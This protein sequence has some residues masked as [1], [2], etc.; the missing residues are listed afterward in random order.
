MEHISIDRLLNGEK[1]KCPKCQMG[2]IITDCKDVSKAHWFY[3]DNK[4]CD[5]KIHIDPI[6]N[7]E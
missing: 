1:P 4:S 3:C 6:I 7:I 5:Y 2:I